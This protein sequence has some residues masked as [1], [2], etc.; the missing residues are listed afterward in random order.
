MNYF[1]GIVK[2]HFKLANFYFIEIIGIFLK[3]VSKNKIP[4]MNLLF[5]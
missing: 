2:V 1:I 3:D 4:I 5:N